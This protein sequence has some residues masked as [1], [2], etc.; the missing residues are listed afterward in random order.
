MSDEKPHYHGHRQRLR[1]RFLKGGAEADGMADYEL[2]E[3]VLFAAQTRGDV[4]PVAKALIDRFGGFAEV[5]SAPPEDLKTVK[6]VGEGGATAIA[7]V[8]A[9]AL[10]MLSQEVAGKPILSNWKMLT[11][12]CRVAMGFSKNE[13]F[14]VLFLNKRNMVIADEVQQRGTVDETPVY[15]R[16]V[17][18]RALELGAT[19]LILVHNHPS[20]DPEPS[21]DD[22]A[23]TREIKEVAARMD[24]VLHDHVI[25]SR[26]GVSSLKQM[27]LI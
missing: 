18:R 22:I 24:I 6:G 14:R 26:G 9:A 17:I 1:E 27:G 12:Y 4:K 2:L 23:I 19:A 21:R 8:R 3:M 15:P 7:V 25:V 16:E 11:D 20:G 13:Q 5:M 10:R